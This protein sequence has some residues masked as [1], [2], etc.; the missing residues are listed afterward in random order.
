MSDPVG[1]IL[2]LFEESPAPNG[3]PEATLARRAKS[4]SDFYHV[5]RSYIHKEAAHK[6][7]LRSPLERAESDAANLLFEDRY[8]AL[9]SSLLDASHEEYQYGPTFLKWSNGHS[10]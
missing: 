5:A 10:P 2:E 6:E 7:E 9:E 3:P 4:Y 8:D 1:P